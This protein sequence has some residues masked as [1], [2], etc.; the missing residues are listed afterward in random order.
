[1]EEQRKSFP[2]LASLSDAELNQ[3]KARFPQTDDE[4]FREFFWDVCN[5]PLTAW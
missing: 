5:T 4:S 3:L 2:G 1:M